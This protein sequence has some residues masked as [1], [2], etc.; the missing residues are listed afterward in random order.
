MHLVD[1]IHPV[2]R[3]RRGKVD[4]FAKG[5]DIVNAVVGSGVD[6]ADIGNGVLVDG[7]TY[8]TFVAG[9]TVFSVKAVGGFCEDLRA[10]RL[11]RAARAEQEEVVPGCGKKTADGF[12]EVGILPRNPFVV[13]ENP[14]SLMADLLRFRQLEWRIFSRGSRKGAWPG[15]GARRGMRRAGARRSSL[16]SAPS[17]LRRPGRGL[18]SCCRVVLSS[19]GRGRGKAFPRRTA[20]DDRTTGRQDR[21]LPPS[22]RGG[23]F[24]VVP[25]ARR[26]VVL[27]K[28]RVLSPR[29]VRGCLQEWKAG[30]T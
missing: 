24:L 19:S 16:R 30:N 29:E 15:E 28:R 2:R 11:A 22:E 10:G 6:L 20:K 9:V 17:I 18:S 21:P 4:L 1:D 25:S 26:L 3:D 8:L 12:H 14:P 27:A 13:N 23:R 5:P 7:F